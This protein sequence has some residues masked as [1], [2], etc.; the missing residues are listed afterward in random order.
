L[1]A[2]TAATS[3]S[4]GRKGDAVSDA[5]AA[6]RR[7]TDDDAAATTNWIPAYRLQSQRE[8]AGSPPDI[9]DAERRSHVR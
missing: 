4:L 3:A 8:I 2:T 1:T 6:A 5:A 7:P 9:L